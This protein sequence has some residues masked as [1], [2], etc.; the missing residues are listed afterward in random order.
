MLNNTPCCGLSNLSATNSCN[1]SYIK[2]Q[3]RR[4]ETERVSVYTIVTPFE[5]KLKKKL[6]YLGFKTVKKFTRRPNP[7]QQL[8]M[9]FLDVKDISTALSK[10]VKDFKNA[11]AIKTVK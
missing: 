3:L 10:R 6:S 5:D 8:S 2:S 1:F 4:A 9:M 7:K 11:Q